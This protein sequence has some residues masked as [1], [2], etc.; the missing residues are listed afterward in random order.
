MRKKRNLIQ[1]IRGFT[2]PGLIRYLVMKM[3]RKELLVQ[4]RCSCCGLCCQN[5]SLDDGT[6]WIRRIEDFE[7]IVIKNPQYTCFKVIGRDSF[8]V[9]QFKCSHLSA[10]NRCTNYQERFQFCIDF[11]DKNLVF[12]GGGLPQGCGYHITTVTPFSN[13]LTSSVKAYN[14]KNSHS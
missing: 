14:E 3:R 9:L 1:C 13:V 2:L 12:C 6:G 5:L 4:G 8:G 10:D 7:R 11:P